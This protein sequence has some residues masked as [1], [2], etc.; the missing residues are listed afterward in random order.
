MKDIGGWIL[1]GIFSGFRNIKDKVIGFKDNFVQGFKDALGIKSP[2][3]VMRDEVGKYL[4]EGIA[5]GLSRT[6]RKIVDTATGISEGIQG[7][8]T[9]VTMSAGVKYRV[10]DMGSLPSD[11][12][13][14]VTGNMNNTVA[15]DSGNFNEGIY[16][17]VY[18][19][20]T[21]AMSVDERGDVILNVDGT[22][23]GRV[24][25]KG[26]NKVSKQ[27]GRVLLQI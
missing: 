18:N 10:G 21:S 12:S 23:L 24:A 26:I 2:S 3:R 22:T 7:A 19:A 13:V 17:A 6:T 9:D 16:G 11:M 1:D 15:L 20:V 14:G 5:D 8:F 25:I 27:E 4:G